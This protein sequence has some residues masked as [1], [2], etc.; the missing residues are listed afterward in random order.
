MGYDLRPLRTLL[1]P[2]LVSLVTADRCSI[3]VGAAITVDT[4]VAS[5]QKIESHPSYHI[6]IGLEICL[7]GS[8]VGAGNLHHRQ[9]M[10]FC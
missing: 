6:S 3:G 7:E 9:W 4:V 5:L 8:L 10:F 2:A 1:D